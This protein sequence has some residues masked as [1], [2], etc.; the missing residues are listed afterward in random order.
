MTAV[1][2]GGAYT[3]LGLLGVLMA[4][5]AVAPLAYLALSLILDNAHV[6]LREDVLVVSHRPLPWPGRRVP[7]SR[8]AAIDVTTRASR[9]GDTATWELTAVLRDGTTVK[10]LGGFAGGLRYHALEEMAKALT[11][12]LV[13]PDRERR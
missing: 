5:P 11:A 8:L 7:I 6:R 10:L 2:G 9:D 4:L 13:L 1:L 12:A 3:E